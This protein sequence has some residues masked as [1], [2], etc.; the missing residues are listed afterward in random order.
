MPWLQ[1]SCALG[2]SPRFAP[3]MFSVLAGFVEPG[4]QLEDT[5][6]REIM[7]EVNIS[8][9]DVVY[10]SSQ[11]WPFPSSLMIGFRARATTFDVVADETEL[12][13]AQW[14]SRDELLGTPESES[15][16]MPRRD[17]IARRLLDDW[18]AEA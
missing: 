18:L 14:Y 10:Q 9:T 6:R 8:V 13:W 16:R 5:V 7:E 15:F 11:P 12:E 17:S 1:I 3:G 2:R 4:E